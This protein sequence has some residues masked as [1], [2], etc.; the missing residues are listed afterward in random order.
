M[1][2]S[3][4]EIEKYKAEMAKNEENMR[5]ALMRGVC[6]LNME[7]MSIFN[8][9]ISNKTIPTTATTNPNDSIEHQQQNLFY[10]EQAKHEEFYPHSSINQERVAKKKPATN[11]LNET[12]S[13]EL[14]R[15]VKNYCET[16]LNKNQASLTKAKQ[17]LLN[18]NREPQQQQ[19]QQ[20]YL[21]INPN[22]VSHTKLINSCN[23]IYDELTEHN[24]PSKVN[25]KPIVKS[26]IGSIATPIKSSESFQTTPSFSLKQTSSSKSA[27]S[28]LPP[29]IPAYRSFIIEKHSAINNNNNVLSSNTTRVKYAPPSQSATVLNTVISASTH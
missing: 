16:N 29:Q 4:T 24:L 15:R 21:T 10:N 25:N 11:H 20:Q 23:K 6:A 17:C 3:R 13:Q 9:T 12:E 14:A 8:E 5:K 2:N 19:Q 7:A 22:V 18:S 1:N 26:K 27:S 28:N